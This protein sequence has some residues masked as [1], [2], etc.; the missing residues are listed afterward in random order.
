MIVR[1]NLSLNEIVTALRGRRAARSDFK[2][3]IVVVER[4]CCF[5]QVRGRESDLLTR[6]RRVGAEK[7]IASERAVVWEYWNFKPGI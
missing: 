6:R 1:G 4:K 7:N 5:V 2:A 3:E